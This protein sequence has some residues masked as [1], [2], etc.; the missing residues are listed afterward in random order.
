MRFSGNNGE[1]PQPLR[2]AVEKVLRAA[3]TAR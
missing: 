1:L 3:R 2:T